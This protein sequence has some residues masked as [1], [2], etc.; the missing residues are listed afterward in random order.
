MKY[1]TVL[2][3]YLCINKDVINCHSALPKPIHFGAI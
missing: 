2:L 3:L 1:V